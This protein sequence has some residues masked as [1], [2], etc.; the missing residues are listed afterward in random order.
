ME[1]QQSDFIFVY[2]TLRSDIGSKNKL[3]VQI[4]EEMRREC[5]FLGSATVQG[6]M[7]DVGDF[8]ALVQGQESQ[9]IQG[10]LYKIRNRQILV[11]LDWFEGEG[12]LYRRVV[13]SVMFENKEYKAYTYFFMKSVADMQKVESGDYLEYL[14]NQD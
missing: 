12:S 7:F 1:T 4:G 3:G 10:E 5:D 14:Q 11:N 9:T 6:E 8:P 2:G 13:V